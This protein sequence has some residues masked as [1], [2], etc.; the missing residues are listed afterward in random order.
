MALPPFAD[1]F[2]FADPDNRLVD[3]VEH[4]LMSCGEFDTVWRPAPGW[5]AARAPLPGTPPDPSPAQAAG[6][7]FAQGIDAVLPERG[8]A[9]ATARFAEL[10]QHHPDRLAEGPGD[11]TFLHLRPNGSCTAVRA[12][13]G[14][15]PLHVYADDRR[16]V[17]STR[18]GYLFRFVP[19]LPPRDDL[20]YA[21]WS[22]GIVT[23]PD[24]RSFVQGFRMVPRGH[25][26]VVEPDGPARFV[27]YWD[28]RPDKLDPPS[29]L[30]EHAAELR[31]LLFACLDRDL[32]NAGALL[33]FSGGVD[34]SALAAI[35]GGPLA[36]QFATL[37]F[38][39]DSNEAWPT[40]FPSIAEV[41]IRYKPE[42]AWVFPI[43]LDHRLEIIEQ[44]ESQPIPIPHPVL[45]VLAR[46]APQSD[47]QVLVGGEA[48][49][50]VC[51]SLLTFGDWVQHTSLAKLLSTPATRLPRDRRDR[52]RWL[53]YR[54]G[55][56]R[57]PMPFTTELAPA[58]AAATRDEYA[59]WAR[60]ARDRTINDPR[61]RRGL[62][63]HFRQDGWPA[64]NWEVTSSLGIRRSVPFFT[65][66]VLELACRCHPQELIGPGTKRLLRAALADDVPSSLLDQTKRTH[67][68]PS[69]GDQP[70]RLFS[71]LYRKAE[72]HH[73]STNEA[74]VRAGSV[75]TGW[76]S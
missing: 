16:R 40:A 64:M 35:I 65:R 18:A 63:A 6:L 15:V 23:F 51:G 27:P 48:A 11:F 55:R 46:V 3:R 39:A 2:A 57:P 20:V 17:I 22:S 24:D 50:A 31:R 49:D 34:S 68:V 32:P 42:P 75:R 10:A 13:N 74:S 61:P 69:P 25:A 33:S 1:L 29:L 30:P 59:E 62:A 7:A 47:V 56:A 44:A 70:S 4:T 19:D 5:V 37:S 58:F 52:R 76:T 14:L 12:C 45:G 71:A 60:R 9:D 26:A 73:A 67:A 28:P 72:H 43:S 53:A 36:K 38:V 41:F 54:R 66:E 21:M 8:G